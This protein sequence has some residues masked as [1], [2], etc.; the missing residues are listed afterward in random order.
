MREGSE[1]HGSKGG[2]VPAAVANLTDKVTDLA[3]SREQHFDLV[4]M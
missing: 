3:R 1:S 2:T 4:Q